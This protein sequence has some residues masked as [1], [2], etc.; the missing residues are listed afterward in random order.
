MK[1]VILAAGA[2]TRLKPYTEVYQ[3]SMLT[4]HGKP[5]LEYL[6]NGLIFA[7]FKEF[8]IVVGYRKEQIIDYFQDGIKWGIKIKYVDQKNLNGTGGALL[9]CESMINEKHFFLTWGDVLIPFRIYKKVYDTFQKEK[10]DFILLTNYAA[11]PYKGGT[12][13]CKDNYCMEI[14]EKSPRGKSSSNL[15]NCG[16]FILSTDIFEVLKNIKHS[17]R[18]EI[19]LTDAINAGIKEKKWKVHVIKMENHQFRGDFGDKE[20]YENLKVDSSWLKELNS[21]NA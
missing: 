14:V 15:N 16:V 6:I 8:I 13:Y 12:V 7:G 2:G 20:V 1:A 17:K 5:L 21:S 19:E 3:K 11:D 10:Q 4:L 9:L 18:G